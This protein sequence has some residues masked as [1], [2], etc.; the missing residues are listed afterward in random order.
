MTLQ[1]MVN[2]KMRISFAQPDIVLAPIDG[3]EI[4]CL[5]QGESTALASAFRTPL[6]VS[7]AQGKIHDQL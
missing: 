2:P 6:T 1:A 5:V 4:W 3:E 7:S